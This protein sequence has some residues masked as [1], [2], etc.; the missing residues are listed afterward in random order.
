M[1]LFNHA[2]L[3]VRLMLIIMKGNQYYGM[4]QMQSLHQYFRIRKN[5]QT[6]K[7]TN[8][9]IS[10]G[11]KPLPLSLTGYPTPTPGEGEGSKIVSLK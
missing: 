1:N 2:N 11:G 8:K 6:N 4:F 5:K 3:N 9:Q 7:Q 10:P